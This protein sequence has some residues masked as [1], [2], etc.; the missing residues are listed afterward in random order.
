M[1]VVGVS[2]TMKG[3][4]GARLCVR[5]CALARLCCGGG[6]MALDSRVEGPD[7]GCCRVCFFFQAEDGIRDGHVTGVQTCDLPILFPPQGKGSRAHSLTGAGAARREPLG[8]K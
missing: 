7:D 3:L 1:F 5:R 6:L 8:R 4:V 2:L